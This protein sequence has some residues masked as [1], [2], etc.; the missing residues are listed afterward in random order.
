MG[1]LKS[2]VEELSLADHMLYVTF[3]LLNDK[4]IFLNAVNHLGKSITEVIRAFMSREVAFKR[5]KFM[6]P[7]DLLI[8]E[9]IDRYSGNLGLNKRLVKMIKQVTT[10]NNVRHRSSIKLKRNDKFIVISPEYS[11]SALTLEEAKDYLRLAREFVQK[12][13]GQMDE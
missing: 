2:A 5:I 1:G 9:F 3:P 4:Q 13:R 11:M 8:N 6:P 7:K 12:M 10:F